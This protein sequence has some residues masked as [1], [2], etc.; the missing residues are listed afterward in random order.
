MRK[1]EFCGCAIMLAR[2][3]YLLEP[4]AGWRVEE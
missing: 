3:E 1:I 4:F 2:F